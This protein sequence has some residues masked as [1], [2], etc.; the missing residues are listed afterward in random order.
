[1]FTV[2]PMVLSL[3]FIPIV[4]IYNKKERC[5]NLLILETLKDILSSNLKKK[6]T[7]N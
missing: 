1:M 2:F 3:V 7:R 5:V 4:A 6:I